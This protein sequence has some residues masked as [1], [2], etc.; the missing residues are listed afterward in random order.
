MRMPTMC[1]TASDTASTIDEIIERP[2]ERPLIV[3]TF[4]ECG[5]RHRTREAAEKCARAHGPTWAPF[6]R[7]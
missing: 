4:K 5:H 3:P 6:P 1:W 2:G 7:F